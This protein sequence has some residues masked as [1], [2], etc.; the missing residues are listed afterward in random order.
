[1]ESQSWKELIKK[2]NTSSA[3][4]ALGNL[5]ITIAKAFGAYFSGSGAMLATTFHSLADSVNQG[6]VFFGSV[7]AEKKPTKRF[8]T[9]FGRVI[10]IFVMVAVIIVTVL[11]YESIKEGWHLIQHPKESGAFWLNIGILLFNVIIDGAILIKVMKEINAE[12]HVEVSGL[13]FIPNSIKHLSEASPPTRLVFF[14]DVVAVTGALLAIIGIVIVTFTNFA[15]LDGVVTLLIGVLMLIIAFRIGYE[16][17]IGL[18]GVAAP[19]DVERDVAKQILEHPKVV[20]IKRM[21]IVKEGRTYHVEGLLELEEDL[22]LEEADDIKFK[23]WNQLLQKKD[24]SDVTL[25]IIETDNEEDWDPKEGER[26]ASWSPPDSDD[27]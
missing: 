16:N 2:G 20:D 24:I 14:E 6:F 1:M 26:H 18:I 9:G 5:V 22:S 10:N 7:L 17:M 3:T 4:A 8:P 19:V 27:Q 21:R 15:I 12:A 13:S 25:G 11:G 23:V